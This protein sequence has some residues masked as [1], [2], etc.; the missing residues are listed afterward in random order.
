MYSV[1]RRR[2]PRGMFDE[3]EASSGGMRARFTVPFT[4]GFTAVASPADVFTAGVFTA[5]VSP[6]DVFTAGVSTAGFLTGV[7]FTAGLFT[8]DG[9]TAGG[10]AAGVF[11]YCC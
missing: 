10:F 7:V 1:E 9:F 11:A 4:A 6:A 5:G 3:C 8:G 2:S